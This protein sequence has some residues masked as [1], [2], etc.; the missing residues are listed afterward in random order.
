MR[1]VAPWVAPDL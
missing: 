1:F